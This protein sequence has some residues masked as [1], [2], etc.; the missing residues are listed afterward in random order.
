MMTATDRKG[1][2]LED[3][4]RHGR[5]KSVSSARIYRRHSSLWQGILP[6][7]CC[8]MN[9]AGNATAREIVGDAS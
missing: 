1:I 4:M 7:R 9:R 5:W 6:K 2:S 3:A 8:R